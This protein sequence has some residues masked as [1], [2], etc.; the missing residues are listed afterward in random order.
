[1]QVGQVEEP[2]EHGVG[3]LDLPLLQDDIC[4][5]NYDRVDCI[6]FQSDR[7]WVQHSNSRV[8]NLHTVQA[9]LADHQAHSQVGL[10]V[11]EHFICD[12]VQ[13]QFDSQF[14]LFWCRHYP[15]AQVDGCCGDHV[16]L[17]KST[18]KVPKVLHLILQLDLLVLS[19]GVC[20]AGQHNV[21]VLGCQSEVK[22]RWQ[23]RLVVPARSLVHV[24]VRLEE[25]VDRLHADERLERVQVRIVLEG[26]GGEAHRVI[27][28]NPLVKEETFDAYLQAVEGY[29][30][31]RGGHHVELPVLVQEVNTAIRF[32]NG[33]VDRCG[34]RNVN[35]LLV[36]ALDELDHGALEEADEAAC[37]LRPDI[38]VQMHLDVLLAD[39]ELHIDS[40]NGRQG[41]SI[42]KFLGR[43]ADTDL[44]L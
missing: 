32:G 6:K 18:P 41:A 19:V 28:T 10:L 40:L 11:E 44:Q 36:G 29:L 30:G 27:V 12:V 33:R 14:F 38:T 9:E 43:E 2:A 4:E 13:V 17:G 16:G 20:H 35:C 37:E 15:E 8:D 23:L 26:H 34:Q 42:E 7:I 22:G 1:M 39:H 5:G 25:R 24:Q 31:L 21:Q 3:D